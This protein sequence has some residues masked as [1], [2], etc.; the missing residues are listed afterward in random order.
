VAKQS[1]NPSQDKERIRA[2]WANLRMAANESS[3]AFR[4]RVEN[5]QLERTAVGLAILPDE[6]IIIGILNRLDMSRYSALVANYLD[7]ER[8]GICPLPDTLPKLWKELKDAHLVRFRGAVHPSTLESVFMSS[9]D[10]SRPPAPSRRNTANPGRGRGR[11]RPSYPSRPPSTA[12][13]YQPVSSQSSS[14]ITC[15]SC[16]EKGHRSN[17]CTKVK[18]VNFTDTSDVYVFLSTVEEFNPTIDDFIPEPTPDLTFDQIFVSS[19]SKL[20]PTTLSLDTQASIHIISNAD[21]L[22][23][24]GESTSYLRVQGITNDVT[25]VSLQGTLKHLHINAYHS[26]AA[27]A[28][29]LSYSKLK[30]THECTYDPNTDSFTAKPVMYGPTLLFSNVGGHYSLDIGLVTSI[31]LSTIE[32]RPDIPSVKCCRPGRPTTLVIASVFSVTRQRPR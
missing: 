30:E 16:G 10:Q 22:Y 7:N 24:V 8:R 17:A 28:N 20:G 14:D 25:C 3:F 19:A 27:A 6:E 21:L 29:I 12:T 1:G 4:T 2:T 26:L 18:S 32:S 15:W 23:S 9:V 5:Y 13:T 11:G 31:Y